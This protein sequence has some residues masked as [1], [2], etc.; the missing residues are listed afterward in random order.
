M[1]LISVHHENTSEIYE[2]WKSTHQQRQLQGLSLGVALLISISS[3]FAID[4][5]WSKHANIQLNSI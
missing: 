1:V 5:R 4:D 2:P 3:V